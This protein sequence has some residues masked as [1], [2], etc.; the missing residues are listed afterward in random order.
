MRPD[1]EIKAASFLQMSIVNQALFILMIAA[2]SDVLGLI[3][4]HLPSKKVGGYIPFVSIA[5]FGFQP[6]QISFSLFL[7]H[8]ELEGVYVQH[9]INN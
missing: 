3:S 7:C 2:S 4:S 5:C 8:I 1:E 9:W 6:F